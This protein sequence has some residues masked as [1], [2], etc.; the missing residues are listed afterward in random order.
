VLTVSDGVDAGSVVDL[1]GP[2]VTECLAEAGF[3]VVANDCVPDGIVPVVEGLRRLTADF[4]GLVVTTG[5]TGFAPRDLTPEATL[6]VID[7]EAPA[8]A[9][10]MHRSSDKARLSRGVA[11][12]RGG[13]LVLNVPG[14]PSAATQCLGAVIDVVPHALALLNGEN[15]HPRHPSPSS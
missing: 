1:S 7:R 8:L 13:C 9:E 3:V 11:G 10:A 4:S 2:A 14:S 6:Q 12:T 15:P 5:G